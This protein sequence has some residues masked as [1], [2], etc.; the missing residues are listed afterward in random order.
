MGTSYLQGL[1]KVLVLVIVTKEVES[2]VP[3][4]CAM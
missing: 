2:P 3:F 1:L 4:I